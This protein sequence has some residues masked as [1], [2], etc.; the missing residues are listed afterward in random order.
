MGGY[1]GTKSAGDVSIVALVYDGDAVSGSALAQK[2]TRRV[3][4]YNGNKGY[5]PRVKFIFTAKSA[6]STLVFTETSANSDNAS[7]VLDNV[8]VR[9]HQGP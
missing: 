3:G 9:V 4:N 7:P 2:S 6:R 1:F 8:A 5:N